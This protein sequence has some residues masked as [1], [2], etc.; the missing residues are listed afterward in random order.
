M[1]QFTG[2]GGNDELANVCEA[3]EA[4]NIVSDQHKR[5]I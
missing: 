5:C 4:W 1:D 3:W 2:E